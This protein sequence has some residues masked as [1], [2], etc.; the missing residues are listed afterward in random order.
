MNKPWPFPFSGLNP[1][2]PHAPL[3]SFLGEGSL[4][5]DPGMALPFSPILMDKGKV[6]LNL[7]P[8]FPELVF[9]QVVEHQDELS[10]AGIT[11]FS[12]GLVHFTSLDQLPSEGPSVANSSR[13]AGFDKLS[14]I[15]NWESWWVLNKEPYLQLRPKLRGGDGSPY[16]SNA[17][18]F[19]PSQSQV[20]QEVL[21]ALKGIVIADGSSELTKASVLAL[22]KV[23]MERISTTSMLVANMS[24]R[25]QGISETA[26]LGLGVLGDPSNIPSLVLI[27]A[28][29]DKGKEMVD[30]SKVPNRTRAFAAYALGMIGRHSTDPA[31][32]QEVLNALFGA[33]AIDTNRSPSVLHACVLSMGVLQPKD[34]SSLVADLFSVVVDETE[35][36]ELRSHALNAASRLLQ[37][38]SFSL[39]QD[40]AEY[41]LELMDQ[42]RTP[43]PMQ[44]SAIQ[45]LGLLALGEATYEEDALDSLVLTARKAK[46]RHQR[47]LAMISLGQWGVETNP[48]SRQRSTIE[49]ALVSRLRK[50]QTHQKGWAALGLGIFAAGLVDR[51]DQLTQDTLE[52]LHQSFRRGRNS[53]NKAACALALAFSKYKPAAEDIRKS[54]KKVKDPGYRGLV[55]VSLG[56]MEDQN[57]IPLLLKQLED[58]LAKP[59]LLKRTAL[60]LA[61]MNGQEAAGLL[62]EMLEKGSGKKPTVASVEASSQALALLHNKNAIGP[63]LAILTNEKSKDMS[64]VSAAIALGHLVEHL[65]F[66]WNAMF[67]Q[68]INYTVDLPILFEKDGEGLLNQD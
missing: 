45:A 61:L 64:R 7:D 10:D 54:L 16:A 9:V 5:L 36:D 6:I 13:G 41:C 47:S 38:S 1:E 17:A 27:L 37:G 66:P 65:A 68:D 34:P 60:G 32:I 19:L 40:M 8:D 20:S 15:K 11:G 63:L 49:D 2:T 62:L 52:T 31:Q 12:N 18:V 53:S 42:R 55:A 3:D 14:D 29:T 56:I 50:A 22:A 26:V 21:P 30:R 4:L 44:Q 46:D 24:H 33:F 28:N 59:T 58:N 23:G 51:G 39:T 48:L 57:A 25:N 43:K 67:G 35:T